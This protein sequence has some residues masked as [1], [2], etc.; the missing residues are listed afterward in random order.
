MDPQIVA[1]AMLPGR[2]EAAAPGVAC[3][4][5]EIPGVVACRPAETG[6]GP[7]LKHGVPRANPHYFVSHYIVLHNIMLYDITLYSTIVYNRYIALHVVL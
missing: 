3:T 7:R 4:D 2:K 5:A 6:I 1:T